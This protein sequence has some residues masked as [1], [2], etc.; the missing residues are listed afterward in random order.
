MSDLKK[1]HVVDHN[2]AIGGDEFDKEQKVIAVKVVSGDEAF[3]QAM[4]K[5]PPRPWSIHSMKLYLVV[6]VG[7]CCSTTNGYDGSLFSTLLANHAFKDFF[8][9]DNAGSWTGI[10]TAMYQIGSVVVI[11]LIGPSID[12]WGRRAAMFMSAFIIIIGVII[13]GTCI[14]TEDIGQFM[15]GRFL[16]GFGVGILGAAGPTYVVEMSHPAHRGVTTG[17]YN[18]FWPFGALLASCAARGGLTYA[19]TNTS[20]MIPVWLQMFFPMIIFVFVW[21][22]PESPRWLYVHGRVEEARSILTRY[23]GQGN[24]N[25]E[26]VK[27]QMMEYEEHLELDGSDKHWWDYRALFRDRASRNRL[28]VNCVVSLFGQWAGNGCVSYFLSKF[29]ETANIKGETMQT[30]LAVGMNAIQIAFAALGAS[31]VDRFGRR[32]MLIIVNIVCCMCWIAI[33]V[34]SSIAD[35]HKDS[36]DEYLATVPGSV[37]KACLAW[38][39]IFQICYSVGW[40]P[41]QALYPVE[42]LSFEMRAKGMAFSSLFTSVGLLANQF[43]ISVALDVITWN[44]YT[45]FAV[46]C[47]VQ[48]VILYFIVPETKNRTLEELD[49]IFNAKNPVKASIQKKKLEVDANAN[50][51]HVDAVESGGLNL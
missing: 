36:T 25:S 10:V 41:M 26:W 3:Q 47:A 18:V 8:H 35:V 39:Y 16:L 50:V 22:L 37:S 13:Q 24:P 31:Q 12:T 30:N 45:V 2:E 20:W 5:E 32:P 34:S 51:V 7:F 33:T 23:H 49:E 43:G 46:W 14:K 44:T 38:V 19:G 48:S 21:I 27:L 11:P 4:I 29:L 15:G 28:M 9:V 40:T 6:I 42:V 17:L 1:E